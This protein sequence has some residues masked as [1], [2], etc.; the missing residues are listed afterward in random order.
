M[1]SSN[2]NGSGTGTDKTL[3]SAWTLTPS[4]GVPPYTVSL[5]LISG[6]LDF[7]T[8]SPLT[9]AS[10]GQSMA[11]VPAGGSITQ[12]FTSDNTLYAGTDYQATVRFTCTDSAGQTTSADRSFHHIYNYQ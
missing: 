10:P 4:G 6:S 5:S 1:Q 11:S 9:P 7:I 8:C 12:S 2:P 3:T